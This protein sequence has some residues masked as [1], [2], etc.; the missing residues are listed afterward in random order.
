MSDPTQIPAGWYDDGS[1][2]QRW[3]DGFQW[4]QF[5]DQPATPAVPAA[6]VTPAAAE[7]RIAKATRMA[8]AAATAAR[9]AT[10]AA[11]SSIA[12]SRSVKDAPGEPV[13]APVPV[14]AAAA[15]AVKQP[16]FKNKWIWVAVVAAFLFVIIAVNAINESRNEASPAE[17]IAPALTQTV[18]TIT[19]PDVVGQD[20]ETAKSALTDLGF[21]V[22]FEAGDESV[23]D[24]S[25]WNVDAQSPV[26]AAEAA[27]GDVVTL[28]V[29]KP[30]PEPEPE[31]V[32]PSTTLGDIEAAQY[33][34][35]AWE[36]RFVYG[37]TVHW[38]VD[39]ITTANEDGTYTFKIGATITNAY[40]TEYS[41]T[42][43]GD[44]GGT[45][46]APVILDSIMYTDAGEVVNYWE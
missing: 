15:V 16:W 3:W 31:P 24:P 9:A 17:E 36:D 35:L 43:E 18:E 22:E 29:S 44:V 42:I 21:D 10:T 14:P 39:R 38:I 46:D 33:L 4:G 41:G 5:A 45:S 13:P 11:A 2:R 20:G 1:G 7:S 12:E 34:A 25:N 23:W 8:T 30:E 32:A 26:A 19:I 6:P 28:T 37:G 27:E 40:G